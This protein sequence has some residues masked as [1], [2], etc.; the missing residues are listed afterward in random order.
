MIE[1]VPIDLP[2]LR[3][4]TTKLVQVACGRAHTVIMTEGEG[5]KKVGHIPQVCHTVCMAGVE[6]PTSPLVRTLVKITAE[7]SKPA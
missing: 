6:L 7:T 1:P 5:G 4:Q 3:P 2:L